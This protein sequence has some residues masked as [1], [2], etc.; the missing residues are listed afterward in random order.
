[1]SLRRTCDVCGGTRRKAYWV[2]EKRE[3][4][5]AR[6]LDCGQLFYGPG[7]TLPLEHLGPAALAMPIDPGPE[8][9]VK[10]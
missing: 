9:A 3:E 4:V 6:C 2:N 7:V 8:G 5:I 10:A 1:M